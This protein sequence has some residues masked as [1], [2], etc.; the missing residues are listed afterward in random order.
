K[1]DCTVAIYGE[2]GTGKELIARA[3]HHKSNRTKGPFITL[4]CGAIPEG[5]LENEFFGHIRGAFPGAYES[6]EGL[7]VQGDGG[8]IFLDGIGNTSP[9]LQVKLL[10]VLQERE[11]KPIGGTKSVKVNV[12]VIVAS[13]TD[14]QKAV[15]EGKFREDLFYRI[16]VVPIY[17]PPLRERK[18]DI[19]LLATYFM[20]GF[21]KVLKKDIKGFTPAAIQRMMLYDWPGNIRE[22]Q[23]KVEHAVVMANK[24]I[25]AT[26]DLFTSAN[27]LKNNFNSYRDAKERFEREY[28]ENLLRINKGNI[29][30]ASKTAK[31]Y[32]ADIYKLIKKHNI[33][34]ENYKNDLSSTNT[35]KFCT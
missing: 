26:E 16:H 28:L 17:I 20:T 30:N 4:N 23:S 32:R 19:P 14:I 15:N 9:A 18:D 11:V 12:R 21:C 24:D 5:L 35:E 1:T 6:K 27:T 10:I 7:F 33:N 8:T 13:N 3:I 34:P 2:S 22:L 31:R 29:T 25:I